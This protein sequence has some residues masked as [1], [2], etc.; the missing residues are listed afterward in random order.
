MP[1][2]Q[3]TGSD[4]R[5]ALP[6]LYGAFRA[7]SPDNPCGYRTMTP[8]PSNVRRVLCA[9]DI[10]RSGSS[11]LSLASLMAERFCA[12]VD[13][14]YAIPEA[15]KLDHGAARVKRLI[16][17]HNAQDRMSRLVHALERRVCVSTFVTRGDATGVILAH[18]RQQSSDLIVM[19]SSPHKH[20]VG[21]VRTIEA[22]TALASC[23]VMTVGDG[24]EPAP[25]RR[26]LLPVGPAGLEPQT[27][28]WV[29]ALASRFD[30]EV[31]VLRVGQ[32]LG[33]PWKLF[34]GTPESATRAFGRP[35]VIQCA[36]VLATLSPLGIESYEIEHPGG[37]DSSAVS[38]LCASARFDAVVVGLPAVGKSKDRETWVSSVRLKTSA[39]VLS[40]RSLVL[41]TLLA[42]FKPQ[43][44]VAVET[45]SAHA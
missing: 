38:D 20:F 4:R 40:V 22:I 24:F 3:S 34:S 31:G 27:L 36:D 2:L 28:S 30:A 5:N 17:E 14:L 25:L 41:N 13:A 33:G 21:A 35:S 42:P 45:G 8:E 18:S 19:A 11:A 32:I 29:S 39:P 16:N 15:S 44:R 12:S 23:A 43:Q 6:L 7:S 26:I 10:E 1:E 37:G 9:L